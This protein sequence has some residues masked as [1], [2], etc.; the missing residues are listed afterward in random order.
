MATTTTI[1]ATAKI[2]KGLSWQTSPRNPWMPPAA[3]E[4][5]GTRRRTGNAN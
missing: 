4:E 3:A 5:S 1:K 2:T